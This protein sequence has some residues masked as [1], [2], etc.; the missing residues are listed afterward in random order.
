MYSV[1]G[2]H[3]TWCGPQGLSSP[4][5]CEGAGGG[6]WV[7]HELGAVLGKGGYP[8]PS[9]P[10]REEVE[11]GVNCPTSFSS[12]PQISCQCFQ[13]EARGQGR[14]GDAVHRCQA[15]GAQHRAGMS[16]EWNWMGTDRQ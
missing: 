10:D 16:V 2:A 5:R 9:R 3:K 7:P 14:L 11:H 4:A 12:W 13:L 8:P 6:N 15:P 1:K